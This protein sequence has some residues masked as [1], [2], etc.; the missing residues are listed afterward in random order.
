MKPYYEP[1]PYRCRIIEQGFNKAGTGTRQFWY[2]FQVLERIVPFNDGLEQ[3]LRTEYYP[4]TEKT[5]DRVMQMLCALGYRGGRFEDVDPRVD[6]FHDFSNL[7]VELVCY[8]EPGLDKTPRE[9]WKVRG[10]GRPVDEDEVR[11][12]NRFLTKRP[13]NS[14]PAPPVVGDI[15]DDEPPF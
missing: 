15:S 6:G 13:A 11:K 7:E 12:L 1:G 5:A 8:H 10:M 9:R 3:Y 4:I 14:S 2:K